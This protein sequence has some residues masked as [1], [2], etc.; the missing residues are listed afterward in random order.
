MA[1]VALNCL[2]LQCL[3]PL[4]VCFRA[5]PQDSLPE[6]ACVYD[7]Q[8]KPVRFRHNYALCNT[9]FAVNAFSL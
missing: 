4:Y 3:F 5:M 9:A 8:M 1:G 7:G 6:Q 2:S